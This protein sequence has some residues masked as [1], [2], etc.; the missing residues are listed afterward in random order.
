MVVMDCKTHTSRSVL[1][2]NVSD[3]LRWEG[4]FMKWTIPLVLLCGSLISMCA[5]ADDAKGT[6]PRWVIIL[7]VTDTTT[8]TRVEQDLDPELEFDDPVKCDSIL[9]R[10]RPIP[11]SG[12]LASALTCRKVEREDVDPRWVIVVTVTDTTTGE[13]LE[14]RELDPELEYNDPVKCESMA[15]RLGP[16]RTTGNLV[17]ALTCRKVHR[18]DAVLL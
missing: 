6:R 2:S 18:K 11:M 9:A 12:N 15:A 16:I 3:C 4:N 14:Q 5:Q 17:A 8:G 7:T 1:R 10:V 13:L